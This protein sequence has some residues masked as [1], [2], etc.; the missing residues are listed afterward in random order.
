MEN[1]LL[2]TIQKLQ[3]R[4]HSPVWH[5]IPAST[6]SFLVFVSLYWTSTQVQHKYTT[7]CIEV[8]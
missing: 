5:C 6:S 2:W 3:D 4:K 8:H 7:K 1:V